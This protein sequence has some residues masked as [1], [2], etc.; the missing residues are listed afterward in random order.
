MDEGGGIG[1]IGVGIIGS[2]GGSFSEVIFKR[3]ES[4]L[5]DVVS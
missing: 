1:G 5:E 2:G 3:I 4:V